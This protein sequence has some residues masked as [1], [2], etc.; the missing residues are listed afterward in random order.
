MLFIPFVNLIFA[1]MI[2]YNFAKSYGRSNGFAV[3]SVFF[4]FVT[5][6]IMAFS[7]G[8]KY[9]AIVPVQPANV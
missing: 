3:L 4:P 8:V 2:S 6:P 5:Y 9:E 7:E 1:I